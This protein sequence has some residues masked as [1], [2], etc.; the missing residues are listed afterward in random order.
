MQ[1]FREPSASQLPELSI[2]IPL[3]VDFAVSLSTLPVLSLLA[4]GHAIAHSLRQLGAASE[5]IFRG[6]RLPSRP[7]MSKKV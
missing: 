4:G 3:P 2:S 5:E 1:S 6:D 7:L